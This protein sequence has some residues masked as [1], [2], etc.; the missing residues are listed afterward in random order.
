MKLGEPALFSFDLLKQLAQRLIKEPYRKPNIPAPQITSQIDYEEWGRISYNTDH[1]LYADT[2]DLFPIE[3]FH[4]GMFFKKA[5]RIN[6]L[7]DGQAREVIYDPSYFNMP[8]NS[9]AHGLPAGAGF[10]GF[11]LQNLNKAS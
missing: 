7:Q 11:R 9:V 5:V 1:A 8:E 6:V 2:N 3:F 4:L 10:A